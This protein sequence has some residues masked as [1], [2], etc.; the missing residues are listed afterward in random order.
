M[1]RISPF[2]WFDTQAEEAMRFYLNIFQESR[3]VAIH[4]YG[5]AG[6]GPKGSVMT[7]VF[8]L[9]GTQFVALNGGPK[10]AFTPAVSFVIKCADQIEI[11]H[12]WNALTADGGKPIECGWLVDKFG[13]SWQVVPANIG[14]LVDKPKV[15]QAVMK[16]KKFDIAALE[17]A[18]DRE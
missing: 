13:L 4:R 5:D 15:M 7:V 6:P 1:E 17:A 8:E 14:E 2:L 3:E 18:R 16:M 9:N 10:F 12:Y 11:D